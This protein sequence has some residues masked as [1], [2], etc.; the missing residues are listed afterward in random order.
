MSNMTLSWIFGTLV[1][2]GIIWVLIKTLYRR[3]RRELMHKKKIEIDV[4]TERYDRGD[5]TKAEYDAGVEEIN[6]RQKTVTI[7]ISEK[8]NINK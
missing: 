1:L 5:I 4:L 6:N 2:T 8:K 3:N 7:N